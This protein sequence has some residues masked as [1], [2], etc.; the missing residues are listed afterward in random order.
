MPGEINA[1]LEPRM[2]FGMAMNYCTLKSKEGSQFASA[3]AIHE[4]SKAT[5]EMAGN[6]MY[7]EADSTSAVEAKGG[8]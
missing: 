1:L 2:L 8:E 5:H 6:Q 3:I 7:L 4:Q